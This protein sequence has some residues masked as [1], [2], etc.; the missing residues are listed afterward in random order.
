[1]PVVSVE[2]LADGSQLGLWRFDETPQSLAEM[3]P[4]LKVLYDQ[5]KTTYRSEARI[6]E[7]MAVQALLMKM[8][9]RSS[10][11]MLPIVQH[12]ESGKPFLDDGR[13]ISISHTKGYAALMLS[14]DHPVGIDIEYR[15]NRVAKI[16]H[17][18]LRDDETPSSVD[19]QLLVWCAKEAAYKLF[20][21]DK[22]TF[23]QMKVALPSSQ[24]PNHCPNSQTLHLT[25][26]LRRQTVNL[27]YRIEKEYVLVYTL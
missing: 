25:N 9:G 23:Q 3:H 17:M 12:H 26:L 4:S 16:A 6:T 7:K 11:E 10:D 14:N 8:D 20:S 5:L 13:Y 2:Q 21:A 18:F 19:E 15:S 1:M 27:N 24:T 22:L